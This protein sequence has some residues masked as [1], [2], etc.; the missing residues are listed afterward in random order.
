MTS[1]SAI[2]LRALTQLNINGK[3]VWIKLINKQLKIDW[4]F[5]WYSFLSITKNTMIVLKLDGIEVPTVQQH[6]Y[7]S[8][9]IWFKIIIKL[10]RVKCYKTVHPMKVVA[11]TDWGKTTKIIQTKLDYGCFI[12]KSEKSNLKVLETIHSQGFRLVLEA[13]STSHWKVCM[14]KLTKLLCQ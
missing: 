13:F 10:L 3:S 1:W 11:H 4:N 12:Y 8:L 14:V 7:L 2:D 9:M 6:K 5:T